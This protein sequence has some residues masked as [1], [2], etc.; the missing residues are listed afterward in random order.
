MA[1]ERSAPFPGPYFVKPR[2]GA[3]SE[4]V[5]DN[6]FQATWDGAVALAHELVSAGVDAMIERFVD[7]MNITVP[8][9][10]NAAPIVLPPVILNT[11]NPKGIL[12][13]EEKLQMMGEMEFSTLQDQVA[14]SPLE[15]YSRQIYTTIAP[16]DYTRIDFRYDQATEELTFLELNVCCDI[17]SFGSFMYSANTL[18]ITQRDIISHILSYSFGRQQSLR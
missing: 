5:S 15:R 2:T 13:H 12:T 9:L 6:S 18:G 4:H 7:G 10:G 17:S 11:R 14:I 8:V 3:A 1:P 16:V